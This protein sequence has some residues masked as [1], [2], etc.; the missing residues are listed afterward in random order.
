MAL[1][2][3]KSETCRLASLLEIDSDNAFALLVATDFN[4]DRAVEH[5]F[6]AAASGAQ[7]SVTSNGDSPHR[8]DSPQRS[9]VKDRDVVVDLTCSP[10]SKR[11]RV[12]SPSQVHDDLAS[13]PCDSHCADDLDEC[14]WLEL[15]TSFVKNAKAADTGSF[16]YLKSTKCQPNGRF[17]TGLVRAAF[18]DR[19]DCYGTRDGAGRNHICDANGILLHEHKM[20]PNWWDLATSFLPTDGHFDSLISVGLLQRQVD[21]S[22]L[23]SSTV[24]VASDAQTLRKIARVSALFQRCSIHEAD[25]VSVVEHA[26]AEARAIW[27]RAERERS[28]LLEQL[29]QAKPEAKETSLGAYVKNVLSLKSLSKVISGNKEDAAQIWTEELVSRVCRFLLYWQQNHDDCFEHFAEQ[30]VAAEKLRLYFEGAC[31]FEVVYSCQ[32]FT[33][34]FL[35]IL[36]ETCEEL[37]CEFETRQIWEQNS[38]TSSSSS[39]SAP[40]SSRKHSPNIKGFT[41]YGT[42][43]EHAFR[44]QYPQVRATRIPF[45]RRDSPDTNIEDVRHILRRH[46]GQLSVGAAHTT[47]QAENHLTCASVSLHCFTAGESAQSFLFGS[48]S[49]KLGS[50]GNKEENA[51]RKTTRKT[52]TKNSFNAEIEINAIVNEFLKK[53]RSRASGTASGTPGPLSHALRSL[54]RCLLDRDVFARALYAIVLAGDLE[55]VLYSSEP[56]GRRSKAQESEQDLSGVLSEKLQ[57]CDQ[58]VRLLSPTPATAAGIPVMAF[59]CDTL[60][61]WLM[62]EEVKA[63]V[64][65]EIKGRLASP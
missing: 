45:L 27:R 50:S 64:R 51:T 41:V 30:Y 40:A 28:D 4:F 35:H 53:L 25:W 15:K 31:R 48:Y 37:L 16:R 24:T 44:E 26:S 22:I 39:A 18:H 33:G 59:R 17:Q 8:S 3:Q 55:R 32:N 61:T 14:L 63:R 2:D 60:A 56:F 5:Y 7:A 20:I 13:S 11:R 49:M 1:V 9:N 65:A 29:Q 23:G 47:W 58:Q 42:E 34:L 62:C 38:A 54:Y 36:I 10:L 52:Q 6:N 43:F 46:S 57:H 12:N 19:A 21:A